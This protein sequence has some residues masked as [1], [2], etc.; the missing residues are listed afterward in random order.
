MK[1]ALIHDW[2][3]VNGGAEKVVRSINNIWGDFD[4]FALIDFL[5]E[6][7][8]KI[9]LK[10]ANVNTSFIQKLPTS[11]KNHRKFLQFFPYAIEKFDLSDYN[12]IISSSSSIAK[13]VKTNQNQLHICYCHSPMRYAWDLQDQYLE[14]LRFKSKI[15]KMYVKWVLKRM[16][17]WD[18]TSNK[19]I[20]Y[21][22]ANS[23][24]IAERINRIY[25]R[26]ATVIYP[27][28]DTEKFQLE[29]NKENYYLAASR[30][31]QYK[32]IDVIVE[33][34]NKMPEK[35][36]VVIGK[37]PEFNKIKKNAKEN[38]RLLGFVPEGEMINYMQK[39]KA[40]I[41]AAEEDFGIVT[42]EA[43]ACGTPVVA[44]DKGGSSEIIVKNETGV[45]F[46]EQNPEAIMD[47]IAKFENIKFDFKKISRNAERFNKERFEKEF[48]SF[49]NDRIN[50]NY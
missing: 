50:K 22:V 46:K 14:N 28:V 15:L 19:N 25:N 16:R 32:N 36:L 38:V 5:N 47:S 3:Y 41:F 12:L 13:G 21:F 29:M 43:Q 10:G 18:L 4:H 11:K 48:R 6:K 20:D 30:L 1:K 26:N 9:I 45:F 37:G 40:F 17:K 8:R 2:Y 49:V 35:E 7:D 33:A 39:A 44:F 31:V 23:N 42:V 24:Y 27:P 34:F